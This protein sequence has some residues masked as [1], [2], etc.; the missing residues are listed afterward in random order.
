MRGVF[1]LPGN[2]K[3]KINYDEE[4]DIYE[5]VLTTYEMGLVKDLI[6]DGAEY[7]RKNDYEYKKLIKN[8]NDLMSCKEIFNAQK[9]CIEKM[10]AGEIIGQSFYDVLPQATIKPRTD[11]QK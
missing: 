2:Q 5:I 3:M 8:E 6:L 1:L 7:N 9:F 10:T 4:N 11:L